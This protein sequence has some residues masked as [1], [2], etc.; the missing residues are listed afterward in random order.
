MPFL[1]GAG[2]LTDSEM[3][4]GS[5][6]LKGF[7]GDNLIKYTSSDPPN[8]VL[9][10]YVK[11]N[12]LFQLTGDPA[13]FKSKDGSWLECLGA[14]KV[15]VIL[16]VR[17]T[18]TGE[19]PGVAHAYVSLCKDLSVHLIGIVQLGGEWDKEFRSIDGLPWCGR[20]PIDR[21]QDSNYYNE[22]LMVV[23]NLIRRRANL[24]FN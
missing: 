21:N 1:V 22:T 18:A 13:S 10:S 8:E 7:W 3:T 14:W 17:P 12:R 6:A 19:I 15:P 5:T 16:F 11:E 2:H 9:K 24:N 4:A 23:E 20:L